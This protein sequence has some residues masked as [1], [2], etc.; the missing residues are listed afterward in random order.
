MAPADRRIYVVRRLPAARIRTI[1]DTAAAWL[2]ILLIAQVVASPPVILNNRVTDYLGA[3][4]YGLY[5]YHVLV[6]GLYM[7]LVSGARGGDFNVHA[8][9]N[10]AA[11]ILLSIGAASVSHR[12]IERPFL[13]FDKTRGPLGAIS[14]Y[15]GIFRFGRRIPSNV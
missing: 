7:A 8:P 12:Y 13:A 5:L 3:R 1:G 4:S 10:Q 9:A 14:R 6:R 15:N 11:V 2:S